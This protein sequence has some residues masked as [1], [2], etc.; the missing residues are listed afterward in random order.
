MPHST[1]GV[2]SS[3]NGLH[4]LQTLVQPQLLKGQRKLSPVLLPLNE[5]LE[6]HSS[7]AGPVLFLAVFVAYSGSLANGFVYDDEPQIL[8]N[9]FIL[10]P[11]LWTR[12]FTGSA[13]SF[14][15]AAFQ[16]SFYRPVQFFSYWLIYRL[17]GPNPAAF[18]LFNLILYGATVWVVYRLGSELL[19]NALAAFVGAL[20]W[21]LHPLHVEAVAWISA[22][23]DVGFGFFYLLAFLL[24]LRAEKCMSA[25]GG[26]HILAALVYFPALF[27]K[28]MALS[29]PLMLLAY[30]FFLG[31]K[32]SWVNRLVRWLPY[33]GAVVCYAAVRSAMLGHLIGTPHLWKGSSRVVGAAAGLLGEHTRLYFWPTHLNVFRT[34][35]VEP[36]LHSPWLWVT[37]LGLS[38]MLW[39][40]KREPIVSFLVV[41]WP[42]GL[43]PALD[44]RQ[45]SFPLLA[46]RFSYLPSV[47]LCLAISFLALSWLPRRLSYVYAPR[48]VLPGLAL[49]TVLWT[50]QTARAIP[51]WRDNE[52][53]AHYSMKQSPN[54]ALLHV[55]HGVVLQY[56][57]GDLDG[58]TREFETA[59][60]LNQNSVRPLPTVT[61]DCYLYLGQIAYQ[62]GHADEAV[63]Y[64]EK[65][66]SVL[67]NY[68]PAYDSLGS[69]YFPRREYA[70]ASQY[71]VQAV[72]V[73]PQ[74][75]TG[76][77][78]LGTCWMKLGKYREA[79]E[80]FRAAREVDPIYW[81]AYEAEARALDAAGDPA[82]AAQVRGLA[83]KR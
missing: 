60:R 32:D 13:W 77:F 28:E 57:A 79:A 35:E 71:F 80:Q 75:L 34:F 45:L 49:V 83:R 55:I 10:N 17:A 50:I 52:T 8:Q 40:R 18:H 65:A 22:L 51:N 47:G 2:G 81:Q 15:G 68:S 20:L 4:W 76:R 59:F 61:Y 14:L 33:V 36:S 54:A 46:E 82:A 66:V 78:Y 37:L 21:A 3:G 42:V 24:F 26:R 12:I 73:N 70:K 43:L 9:P 16:T 64:F 56:Q 67:H 72:K 69:V 30:W 23:P 63:R 6:R 1:G 62:R 74:D 31:A 11:H 19:Q 41:W 48:F 29:F 44:I 27:F 25:R 53:L 38:A 5:R 58:A 39:V 7:L